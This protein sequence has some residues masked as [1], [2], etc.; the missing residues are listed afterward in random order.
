MVLERLRCHSAC[1]EKQCGGQWKCELARRQDFYLE[2][3]PTS[4]RLLICLFA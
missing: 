1:G 2:G 3:R 4:F